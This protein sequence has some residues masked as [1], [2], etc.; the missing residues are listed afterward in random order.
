MA[1]I[2]RGTS[3]LTDDSSWRIPFGL[4]Y[5]IPVIVGTLVWF[6]PEVSEK[7]NLHQSEYDELKCLLQ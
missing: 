5:V 7:T 6:I 4:F 2:C 3:D 1:C